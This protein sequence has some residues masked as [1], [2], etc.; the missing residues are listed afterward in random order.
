MEELIHSSK[1]E[2]DIVDRPEM[3]EE[4]IVQANVV[5]PTKKKDDTIVQQVI[6][7]ND[8]EYAIDLSG[9]ITT[10]DMQPP[11][12]SDSQVT[13]VEKPIT[14]LGV[15]IPPIKEQLV[16]PQ[17]PPV[18]QDTQKESDEKFDTKISEQEIE[19]EQE[20]EDIV[21][22]T[23]SEPITSLVLHPTNEDDDDSLGI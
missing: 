19:K 5:Y 18:S 3:D 13:K 1:Y 17:P 23:S 6:L 21:K 10:L 14:Q 7:V 11:E 20:K 9:D 22:V 12:I 2:Q 4:E 15:D 16:K 8:I